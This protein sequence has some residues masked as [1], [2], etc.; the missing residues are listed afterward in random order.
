M[1]QEFFRH[2]ARYTTRFKKA[3]INGG[4]AETQV[5]CEILWISLSV[6]RPPVL[7]LIITASTGTSN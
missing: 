1:N 4:V 2:V 5:M 6:L 7:L 3:Q